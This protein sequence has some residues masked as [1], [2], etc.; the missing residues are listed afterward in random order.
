MNRCVCEFISTDSVIR[1]FPADLLD[2]SVHWFVLEA[3]NFVFFVGPQ[4]EWYVVQTVH[5]MSGL[6]NSST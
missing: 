2:H 3:L 6:H 4:Y 1:L 5:G